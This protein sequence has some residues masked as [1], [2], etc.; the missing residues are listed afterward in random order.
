LAA[1]LFFP[2][3]EEHSKEWLCHKSYRASELVVEVEA[4]AGLDLG[5]F[6][7]HGQIELVIADGG[8]GLVGGVAEDVLIPEFRVE[9]GIDFVES[10]SLGDFIEMPAGRFGDLFENFLAVGM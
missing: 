9:V 5:V 3:I 4:V 1:L 10:F 7:F 6:L 8:V 2:S